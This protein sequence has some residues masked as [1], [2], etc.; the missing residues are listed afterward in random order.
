MDSYLLQ[1]F[2]TVAELKSFSLAADKL[3]L[4]QPAVSKRIAALEQ[5]LD[6]RVF[7][8]I[9]KHIDLT[10]AGSILL[11]KARRILRE[12]NDTRTIIRNLSESVAGELALATSHHVGLHRLP[13]VLR[14]FT[15]QYPQVSLDISFLSS[16][17][18]YEEVLNG[19]IELAVI[20]LAPEPVDR[21]R[22]RNI[23]TDPLCFM[24]STEH[25]LAREKTLQLA[26]LRDYPA[27]LPGNETFTRRIVNDLFSS[28]RCE[29]N[30]SMTT[31][32]LETIKMM[33][34]I[35]LAWSVLPESM[36]DKQLR[37]LPL[38]D[39]EL[40]RSLG[41]IYHKNRTLSNA[42]RAFIKLLEQLG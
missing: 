30:V 18:A 2:I 10:E 19:N 11:P 20:T 22:S 37:K 8:R 25:P 16:E 9:G 7:D 17:Q 40:Q 5:H 42:G 29:L 36:L 35:G 32:Y 21:I 28:K 12:L 14:G 6:T 26:A 31:N 27:I 34:S 23:W 33:V 15:R 24:A 41:Y 3:G 1:A 38:K 39:I 4:T 13:P